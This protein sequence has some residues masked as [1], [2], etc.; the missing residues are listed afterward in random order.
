ML[1]GAA[2]QLVETSLFENAAFPDGDISS[3]SIQ[4]FAVSKNF[5]TCPKTMK[6]ILVNVVGGKDNTCS[7]HALEKAN[8]I[9]EKDLR[10]RSETKHGRKSKIA[11]LFCG[12]RN[13]Q[14]RAIYFMQLA[15]TC[16]ILCCRKVAALGL[17]DI[18]LRSTHRGV[19]HSVLSE[20]F[21]KLLTGGYHFTVRPFYCNA[22]QLS[23]R[24]AERL[25]TF[26]LTATQK[27][28]H[29]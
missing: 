6:Q 20:Y 10:S 15:S 16:S 9:Y 8:M 14:L 21:K 17:C 25:S 7:I 19:A 11:T 23:H 28:W 13:D 2:E 29:G 12:V 3:T 26:V 4:A 1:R 27:H 22:F 18:A 5:E 24:S